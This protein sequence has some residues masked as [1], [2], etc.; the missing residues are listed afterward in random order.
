MMDS[1]IA[2]LVELA[3]KLKLTPDHTATVQKATTWSTNVA[4]TGRHWFYCFEK[5]F[6]K[7]FDLLFFFFSYC[8]RMQLPTDY[9]L[10]G[11]WQTVI[12]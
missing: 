9:L 7:L 10:Q 4:W 6:V 11:F 8:F 5:K 1:I 3:P 2:S 12:H